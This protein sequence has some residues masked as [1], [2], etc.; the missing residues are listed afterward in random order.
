MANDNDAYPEQP[1]FSEWCILELMGHRRL[2]GKVTE[3][4]IGGHGFLR[5]DVPKAE[6]WPDTQEWTA[7]QFYSPSA[8]Y[9]IT[10]TTETIAMRIAAEA[11]PAPVS[12]WELERP[13]EY[14]LE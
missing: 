10:P 2:A 12:R 14:E 13:R 3:Y 7:T 8:V 5:L 4:Q 6:G 11:Q 1:A 9:C